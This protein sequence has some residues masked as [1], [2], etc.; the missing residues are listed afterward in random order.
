[1]VLILSGA[2]SERSRMTRVQVLFVLING[3]FCGIEG[4]KHLKKQVKIP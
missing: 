2:T 1:V 3:S 4:K